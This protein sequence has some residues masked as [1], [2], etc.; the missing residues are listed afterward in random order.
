MG[1]GQVYLH[2]TIITERY[3]V[4][5]Q[6]LIQ[7]IFG[8]PTLPTTLP[9]VST[10]TSP[11]GLAVPTQKLT[12]TVMGA[13]GPL[14]NY[15]YLH[16]PANP[17]DTLVMVC[18]GH[19]DNWTPNGIG[20]TVT[21][22]VNLGFPTVAI[23]MPGKSGNPGST[24]HD[25]GSYTDLRYFYEVPVAVVN[26]LQSTY[27]D[28]AICGVSGGGWASHVGHALDSRITKSM[29]VAGG[30]PR[31][32][33]PNDSK[34]HFEFLNALDPVGGFSGVCYLAA[35]NGEVRQVLNKMDSCCFD[36]TQYTQHYIQGIVP[37]VAAAASLQGGSFIC[38]EDGSH[39]SHKI[40]QWARDNVLFPLLGVVTPFPDPVHHW[41]FADDGQ[42]TGGS[43]ATPYDGAGF[44]VDPTRGPVASL[45][46]S[47]ARFEIPAI[48]LQSQ[49]TLTAWVKG[50]PSSV[51]RTLFRGTVNHPVVV[52]PSNKL[53]AFDNSGGGGVWFHN[54][55]FTPPVDSNW[56]HIAAVANG[57]HTSFY[58]NGVTVGSVPFV[59]QADVV[60]I[61]N[62]QLGGQR[63]CGNLS[64][65]RFYDVSL[66]QA[67]VNT[68]MGL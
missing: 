28:F 61:G 8:Q 49:W 3:F 46:G 19:D 20:D 1:L 48:D 32:L 9:I 22:L 21:Q 45:V 29:P 63:F 2:N 67:Q 41:T 38:Y 14:A 64:D 13:D 33:I 40:S 56:H 31:Y 12:T 24:D 42:D 62:Y 59:S 47:Y 34:D 18:Q 43:H 15:A 11:F 23:G 53:G 44:V 4:Q 66:T 25:D 10:A 26:L 58:W 6:P 36:E 37:A 57:G 50:L 60:C 39:A 54:S 55:G 52:N 17:R 30:I 7:A 35:L 27:S 16:T 51:W 5:N 65:V 68:V